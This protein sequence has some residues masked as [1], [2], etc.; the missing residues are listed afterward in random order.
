MLNTLNTILF[1]ADGNRK[2]GLGHIFRC[3]ALADALKN[4][5]PELEIIFITKYQEGKTVIR[6]TNYKVIQVSNNEV[7]QIRELSDRN[8]L[9][10]TDFLDTDNLYIS[11]IKKA[12]GVKVISI[13]NNTKLKRIDADIL[14]NANVFDGREM[15][16]MGLTKCFLGP[17]Y[18]ILRKEFEK[19]S[20]EK[21]IN[22]NTESVSI[23]FG[24]TDPRGSTA[25]I[26]KALEN[27]SD[28]IQINLIMG[29]G[30]SGGDTLNKALSKINRKFNLLFDPSNIIK[31]MEN[32]DIAI[33]A[34][35]ITLYELASIG[36]P[37]I[38]IPQVEHQRDIAK[39]FKKAEACINMKKS[40]NN[41]LIYK[42]T[43]M[44]MESKLLRKK[45]SENARSLVDGR[46][47]QRIIRLMKNKILI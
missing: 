36:V 24:G 8:T 19:A 6:E 31:I 7:G 39:A 46:G 44:L 32:T 4:S 40:W 30:F 29:P 42:N 2:L 47:T 5:K 16:T 18:I 1:R 22:D 38:V 20:K 17:K 34:A 26:A 15:Q 13:D 23:M 14:I 27:I 3:I 45:L 28:K 12:T 43:V 37:S 11:K 10:I 9:L 35:G 33:T 25:R 21:E 41:M